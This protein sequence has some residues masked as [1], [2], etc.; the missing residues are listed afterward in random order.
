[1]TSS[2]E[3]EEVSSRLACDHCNRTGFANQGAL[4][5]HQRVCK[6]NPNRVSSN[7]N[8]KYCDKKGF[9][10]E[11]ALA[12]HQ[13][14]CKDNPNRVQNQLNCEYCDKIEFVNEGALAN[15]QRVC[16]DN[17]DRVQIKLTCDHCHR[18][19]FLNKGA[20]AN[21]Q[22]M[23]K[24]NPNRD[25]PKL[26]C[27]YCNKKD[28]GNTGALTSHQK[29]CKRNPN[30]TSV[31]L[32]CK[33]CDGTFASRNGLREHMKFCKRNP[34]Q[35]SV[36]L[37]CNHCDETFAS[38]GGLRE[39]MKVCKLSH[40]VPQKIFCPFCHETFA[41]QED[42]KLHHTYDQCQHKPYEGNQFTTE[43]QFAKHVLCEAILW[44]V[45][46]NQT[47]RPSKQSTKADVRIRQLEELEK[48]IWTP[49]RPH[50][51][52][53]KDTNGIVCPHCQ[54]RYDKTRVDMQLH[55]HICPANELRTTQCPM[56]HRDSPSE[57]IDRT[58][59]E[60]MHAEDWTDDNDKCQLDIF[61]RNH[62]NGCRRKGFKRRSDRVRHEAHCSFKR[63]KTEAAKTD[64]WA[65]EA[66]VNTRHSNT[67]CILTHSPDGQWI[68]LPHL[69]EP[70]EANGDVGL[71]KWPCQP[72][73]QAHHS[74]WQTDLEKYFTESNAYNAIADWNDAVLV[75]DL[76]VRSG[77][78]V[79]EH[80]ANEFHDMTSGSA[81]AR[82]TMMDPRYNSRKMNKIHEKLKFPPPVDAQRVATHEF[83]QQ[84]P[85]HRNTP[86]AIV[87]P[88]GHA[89]VNLLRWRTDTGEAPYDFTDCA[90]WGFTKL[91]CKGGWSC[92]PAR[93]LTEQEFDT[94]VTE[95]RT[96]TDSLPERPSHP[97]YIYNK[98]YCSS[99]DAANDET[100]P[101]LNR[102]NNPSQNRLSQSLRCP[103]GPHYRVSFVRL[104]PDD[105]HD[106]RLCPLFDPENSIDYFDKEYALHH[107]RNPRIDSI[108]PNESKGDDSWEQGIR[109]SLDTYYQF[110][111][112]PLRQGSPG[113]HARSL[114]QTHHL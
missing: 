38:Q 6:D 13:R 2:I 12:S 40:V 53:Y 109:Q 108:E 46:I 4:A 56:Q 33:H 9:V 14:Q 90:P 19:D 110:E 101:A 43:E 47:K 75:H 68:P 11:A 65:E 72:W 98:W 80:F 21:H 29:F 63:R 82:Q 58:T 112:L 60:N 78:D 67:D 10:H 8:C 77:C 25:Q 70:V 107:A 93:K 81:Y 24:H 50:D 91:R 102:S 69:Q 61:C 84:L 34:N 45:D 28:F 55:K 42:F 44:D 106:L 18:E 96:W 113:I 30:Q 95:M 71:Q 57:I 105:E 100:N 87:N 48:N 88:E 16:K 104:N 51:P 59:D 73:C 41:T 62:I 1:M 37:K 99:T 52:G 74:Y 111:H 15:H 31:H 94:Y 22:R 3:N 92:V 79:L 7:F 20:L 89:V 5:N 86:R 64:F 32:K 54:L 36:H 17:P 27:E 39:H 83:L 85:Y 49:L 26:T 23:C 76:Y 35:T 114:W 66:D 97:M 103:G